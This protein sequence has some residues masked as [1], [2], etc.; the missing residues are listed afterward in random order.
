VDWESQLLG[1]TIAGKYKLVQ[2]HASGAFG[3]VFVAHHFFCNHFVRPV[4][5][6]I[7]RQT[8][9]SEKTAPY[10]FGDALIL[11]QLMSGT[12]RD[13]KQHLVHIF[14]M[15]L[16]PEHDF[17][18]FLVM[19][20]VEGLPLLSHIQAAGQIGVAAGLRYLKEICRALALVHAQGA[21]HRDLAPDNILI[22]RQGTV[23]VI[24]FGLAT[25]TD[26]KL[27]F[28]PGSIGKFIY[29]APETSLGKATA[30]ADVYSLGLV[31]YELFTGGGPHLSA[32]W[33]QVRDEQDAN[34][35]YRMKAGLHY[36]PPSSVHNEIRNDF[37]W[38]DALILRCL[39]VNPGRRFRDAGRLLEAMETC[40]AG[41][42]LPEVEELPPGQETQQM[43]ALP[44]P[45]PAALPDFGLIREARQ[46]LARRDYAGVIDHL[47]IHRPA[48]WAVVDVPGARVLRLL[49]RAY[50]EKKDYRN[51][52]ECFGQLQAVQKEQAILPVVEY[53]AALT[54]LSDCYRELGQAEPEQ[55]CR[56]EIHKTF[57]NTGK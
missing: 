46:R 55:Q 27:G 22:D 18:G 23:R 33:T 40:L 30:A 50:L 19:E 5:V 14:D 2:V 1:K 36:P 21:V 49:G 7:S 32:P 42:V 53:L 20:H 51:A 52:V 10:L 43:P 57:W 24:D 4:A 54:E 25:F 35:Q 39:D 11:A 6:K 17:R 44:K 48:E 26:P 29:M 38:V 47:D 16:L 9:L 8:G 12:H 31:A 41:G 15:G 45:V 3:T 34:E 37:P 13:G 28:A 56:E